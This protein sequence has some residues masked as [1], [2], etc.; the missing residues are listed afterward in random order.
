MR[1]FVVVLP[2]NKNQ[3]SRGLFCARNRGDTALAR[4]N[5]EDELFRDAR[6]LWL[7]E[8][9]GGSAKALGFLVQFWLAAQRRW[10]QGELL[11]A[12]EF[13]PMWEPLIKVG[14]AK[15]IDDSVYARGAEERFAWYRT[16][17]KAAVE[18]GKKS[19]KV[20]KSRTGSAQPKAPNHARTIGSGT[21]NHVR[22][23][24]EPN[25]NPPTLTLNIKDLRDQQD[26]VTTPRPRSEKISNAHLRARLLAAYQ[27]YPR[28]R[29]KKDGLAYLTRKSWTE[30]ELASF[31]L[32]VR[33]YAAHCAGEEQRFI[34]HFSTW[35]R[36]EWEDW[37][38]P[39]QELFGCKP[40]EYDPMPDTHAGGGECT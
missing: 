33:N 25:P 23:M 5:I 21:P 12:S 31:E 30:E 18:A 13:L 36:R 15:R 11:P 32:A 1:G 37:V 3:K 26:L 27:A 7:S 14:F 35:V 16:R 29:G 8:E 6:F 19:A 24:S 10:G 34:K 22:T 28:K 9:V 4:I 17:K 39:E 20:R 38:E 2:D 40:G